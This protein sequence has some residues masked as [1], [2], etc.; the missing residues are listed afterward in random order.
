MWLP[1]GHGQPGKLLLGIQGFPSL[2]EVG[3]P[4]QSDFLPKT[5]LTGLCELRREDGPAWRG[6][7]VII[8]ELAPSLECFSK[9][10]WNSR[11]PGTKGSPANLLKRRERGGLTIF[12][13]DVNATLVLPFVAKPAVKVSF[14]VN[15]GGYIC[16]PQLEQGFSVDIRK[17][18]LGPDLLNIYGLPMIHQ[19][20]PGK[21]DP[22]FIFT[23]SHLLNFK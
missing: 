8:P 11:T 13:L 22:C 1:W 16:I 14:K 5:S 21:S 3:K 2:W 17:V 18:K 20:C 15:R 6:A 7:L 9:Q 10:K 4:V 19:T 23:K 12:H